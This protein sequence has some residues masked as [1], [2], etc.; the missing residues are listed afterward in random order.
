MI[1][2]WEYYF[3]FMMNNLMGQSIFNQPLELFLTVI[4]APLAI[5]LFGIIYELYKNYKETEAVETLLFLLGMIVLFPS[6]VGG[7]INR[8]CFATFGS[9][10]LGL[11]IS[12]LLQFPMQFTYLAVNIFAI[13]VTFPKQYRIA[14]VILLILSV[15]LI[16]TVTWAILQGPP[17]AKIT[18]FIV[19]YSLEI[20]IVRFAT[21]VPVAVIPTG[22][23]FYY[24]GKNWEENRP[25]SARAAWLGLAILSFAIGV[26]FTSVSAEFRLF[27]IA[28]L[29]AAIIFYVCFAMP[30]WFKRRIGWPE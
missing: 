22:V 11:V 6:T 21:L 2:N 15:I 12:L 10:E 25:K 20:Q 19:V 5:L 3:E 7:L 30:D 13:R 27:I 16:G 24:A 26:L 8:L 23:F 14:L 28:Y 1:V 9:P 4:Y 17:M 29:P 18:N